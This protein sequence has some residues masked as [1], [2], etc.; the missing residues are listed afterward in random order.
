MVGAAL[1][2]ARIGVGTTCAQ[3]TALTLEQSFC[4]F[5]FA[6]ILGS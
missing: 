1:G 5:V 3:G 6:F 4:V 2:L